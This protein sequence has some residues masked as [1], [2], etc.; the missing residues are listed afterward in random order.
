MT[1]ASN[2]DPALGDDARAASPW[3]RFEGIAM[4]TGRAIQRFYDHHLAALG[5]NIG[6]A[7]LLAYLVDA[8]PCS[9]IELARGLDT[10]KATTALRVDALVKHG[11]VKRE[12]DPDDRRAWVISATAVGRKL[13]REINRID[14]QLREVI[15]HDIGRDERRNFATVAARARSNIER[16][17]RAAAERASE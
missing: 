12:P 2:S 5:L 3:I 8:G 11:A 10:G 16:S 1:T 9:Q 15:R 14:E 17:L 4:S 6:E 13:A 7:M